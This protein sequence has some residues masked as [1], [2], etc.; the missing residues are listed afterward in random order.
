MALPTIPLR[1]RRERLEVPAYPQRAAQQEG[2]TGMV[3]GREASD[4]E[5]R[6]ARA[7]RKFKL[8]FTF[9]YEVLTAV[10]IP[11]QEN[12]V[13]FM[14]W[15]GQPRPVEIDGDFVHKSAGQRMKDQERDALVSQA[16]APYGYLPVMR[17]PGEEIDDQEHTDYIVRD[18]IA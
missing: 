13:D 17:I 6:F 7:L 3:N 4:L 9:Q 14:V 8:D 15:T 2:L 1:R 5:E 16:L 12:Q 18:Y 10:G 11:G